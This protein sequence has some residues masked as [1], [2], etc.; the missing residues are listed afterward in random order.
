MRR[1]D[2][3]LD[4]EPPPKLQKPGLPVLRVRRARAVPREDECAAEPNAVPIG[5]GVGAGV[6]VAY[7]Q[8]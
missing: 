5:A 1:L 6:G 7:P 4:A 8:R 3:E 2:D